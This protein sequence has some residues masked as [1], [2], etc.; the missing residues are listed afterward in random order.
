MPIR[1]SGSARPRKLKSPDPI[2]MP[3]VQANR[4]PHVR[5]EIEYYKEH[6]VLAGPPAGETIGSA[7]LATVGDD[8]AFID[9]RTGKEWIRLS[10]TNS[11]T[12]ETIQPELD[13]GVFDGFTIANASDV[14]E[15][16]RTITPEYCSPVYTYDQGTHYINPTQWNSWN[17]LQ[18]ITGYA[19]DRNWSNGLYYDGSTLKSAGTDYWY[20]SFRLPYRIMK[21]DRPGLTTAYN[22]MSIYLVS[23]GGNTLT[24]SASPWLLANN[25]NSPYN[26]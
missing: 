6:G 21:F 14:E 10:Q 19:Y 18:G 13:G 2:N 1:F 8:I 15:L 17:S 25:P 16:I 3:A 20:E 24:S 26:N 9:Y 5:R 23:N 11:Y 22:Y 12:I 4:I 7:D